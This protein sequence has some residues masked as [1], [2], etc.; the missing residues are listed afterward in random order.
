M[1]VLGLETSC[2]ETAVGIVD[3]GHTVLANEVATQLAAHQPYGG[4][5][6]E[7]AARAHLDVI[8]ELVRRALATAGLT[9]ADIDGIAATCGPGLI[10][11]VMV[12]A[13]TGKALAAVRKLPFMAVN[14]LEAHALTP[15]LTD[16]VAFPYLLLLVSG[17]HTQLL[18]VGG[19]GQYRKLGGTI[20]DAVGECFDKGA[21]MLGLGY[22]G[23][24]LLE[25]AALRETAL[26]LPELPRPMLGRAGCDFSFSGLKTALRQVIDKAGRAAASPDFV[27]AAARAYQ[28]AI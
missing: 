13:M 9:L 8:D 22:P 25:Q 24:P 4:V 2:D 23:G 7:V 21:K 15:R 11:G 6:P 28:A 16:R 26:P 1:R 10:G 5:V 3:D 19:V 18:R 20:D 27:T 12:G 17:G 14:H